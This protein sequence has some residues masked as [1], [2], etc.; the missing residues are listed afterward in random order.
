M[1]PIAKYKVL[2]ELGSGS[3][4]TVYRVRNNMDGKEY[5]MKVIKKEDIKDA[6][7][8]IKT[9]VDILT[10][11]SHNSII[12]LYEIFENADKIC[13]VMELVLGGELFDKVVELGNY[14]EHDAAILMKK[15]LSAVSYLHDMGIVH[16]DL[17]PENLLL[18]TSD[19][20]TSIRVTDFGLSRVAG[21]QYVLMT[22]CGTPGYVAPEVLQ[23]EGYGQAVDL[24]ACGVIL[25]ILLS[26][27]PPFYSNNTATLFNQIMSADYDFD[28]PIWVPVSQEAK[29]LVASLLQVDPS[30]RLTA[31]QALQHPWISKMCGGATNRGSLAIKTNLMQHTS[32]TR[33]RSSS[34]AKQLSNSLDRLRI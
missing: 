18:E 20:I 2:G 1:T 32:K 22:A 19:D 9:E 28:D 13:L 21:K 3:F 27:M 17:K 16:R 14:T 31:K 23:C 24:W 4:S 29:D 34:S 25:Y 26:G 6:H 8:M 33:V 15:L 7:H 11:V 12:K 5:A 30:N 10:R